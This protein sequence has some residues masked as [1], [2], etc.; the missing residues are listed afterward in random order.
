MIHRRQQG[1]YD[2]HS[3]FQVC[4]L[5]IKRKYASFKEEIRNYQHEFK[6]VKQIDIVI[7]KAITFS[8][9]SCIIRAIKANSFYDEAGEIPPYYGIALGNPLKI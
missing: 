1:S 7:K 5:F 8:R 3:G 6:D 2:A 9:D 4:D